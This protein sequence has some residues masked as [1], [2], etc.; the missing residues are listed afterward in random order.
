MLAPLT[1][2]RA[3]GLGS[4]K[5]YINEYDIGNF[6]VTLSERGGLS[7]SFPSMLLGEE[8]K[9]IWPLEPLLRMAEEQGR[10]GQAHGCHLNAI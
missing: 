7:P 6:Q 3:P 10:R 1:V 9:S 8:K 2:G 4:S 5:K